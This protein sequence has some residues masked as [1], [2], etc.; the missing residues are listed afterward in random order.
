MDNSDK[1]KLGAVLMGASL[2]LDQA[3]NAPSP[4]V[5]TPVPKK[6]RPAWYYAKFAT[7]IDYLPPT[8]EQDKAQGIRR[9]EWYIPEV[10][11]EFIDLHICQ[12]Y[13]N[14]NEW[15]QKGIITKTNLNKKVE[16]LLNLDIIKEAYKECKPVPVKAKP[17]WK[18]ERKKRPRKEKPW[19]QPIPEEYVSPLFMERYR[20]RLKAIDQEHYEQLMKEL[21]PIK[22]IEAKNENAWIYSEECAR[23]NAAVYVYKNSIIAR[24]Y[25]E[26][27][28]EEW[29]KKYGI[30]VPK[31]K[32]TAPYTLDILGELP[33]SLIANDIQALHEEGYVGRYLLTVGHIKDVA[34]HFAEWEQQREDEKMKRDYFAWEKGGR[35]DKD[36]ES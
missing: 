10:P 32:K 36:N 11:K 13:K 12:V 26:K 7:T 5:Q 27:R 31:M 4:E 24:D 6:H 16:L 9:S 30:P 21:L 2:V 34:N 19:I 1:L 17:W 29:L 23:C 25:K 3:V 14:L 18:R 28:R 20:Q 35:K 22:E 8:I 33:I 15:E